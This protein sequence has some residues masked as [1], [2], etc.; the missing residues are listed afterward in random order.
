VPAHAIRLIRAALIW[1][2]VGTVLGAVL[3]AA[4]GWPVLATAWALRPVHREVL[5]AG[6]LVQ[7]VVGV[8]SW[9][10]PRLPERSRADDARWATAVF[11]LLNAGVAVAAAGAAGGGP[12]LVAIGRAAELAAVLVVLRSLW[13]RA[14]AYGL[15]VAAGR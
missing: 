9:I 1:F 2:L 15:G 10:L 13:P 8:A 14:R 4:K 6:W 7:L 12:V 11:V 5:L 3:L